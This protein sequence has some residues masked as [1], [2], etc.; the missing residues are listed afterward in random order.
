MKSM[1]LIKRTTGEIYRVVE[2][3]RDPITGR[4]KGLVATNDSHHLTIFLDSL[5]RYITFK[6]QFE[7]KGGIIRD[8]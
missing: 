8:R 1:E 3:Q 4:L 2:I 6:Q 7:L 5:Q